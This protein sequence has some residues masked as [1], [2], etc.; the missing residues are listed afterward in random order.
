MYYTGS[1]MGKMISINSHD[2]EITHPNKLLFPDITKARL[3]QYYNKIARTML[4]HISNRPVTMH[5][6]PEGIHEEGFY[7]KNMP[8]YFPNWIESYQVTKKEGGTTTYIICNNAATLAYL[9]NYDCITP[10]V[11][12]STIDHVNQPDRLIF[13]LDPS[14]HNIGELKKTAHNIRNILEACHL[15]PYVMTTGSQGFHIVAPITPDEDFDTARAFAESVTQ[16]LADQHPDTLTTEIRKKK[17]N[18]RI[19]LDINRIAYAQTGVAPYAV[20]AREQAPVATPITWD[21]L[22]KPDIRPQ[23]YTI[24]NI[25]RRLGQTDDPWKNIERNAGSL[26]QARKIFK[27]KYG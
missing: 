8:D 27:Q 22:D 5:R 12:L 25:F 20:R 3:V 15:T 2:I 24:S 11:W 21:E 14:E 26:Q 4:P 18:G 19:F 7:H 16:Y 9:A 1:I 6:F 13:D 10:H 23:S 17:R